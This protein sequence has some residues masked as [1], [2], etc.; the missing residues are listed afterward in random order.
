[1]QVPVG[2]GP[3]N[4]LK[5]PIS[6]APSQGE[7]DL[8][9]VTG[10]V[11]TVIVPDGPNGSSGT[12]LVWAGNVASTPVP[13]YGPPS[14][15]QI[16]GL[17]SFNGSEFVIG[18]ADVIGQYEISVSMTTPGGPVPADTSVSLEVVRRI[19]VVP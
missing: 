3:P 2:I 8:T 16:V 1:M 7:I 6:S 5:I 11:L 10:L 9:T 19:A 4:Q 18:G 13:P 17:Y 14:P 12:E 15:T